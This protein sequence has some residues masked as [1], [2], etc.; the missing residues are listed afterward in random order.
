VQ[1]SLEKSVMPDYPM[2]LDHS[3]VG[4]CINVLILATSRLLRRGNG[5]V[6]LLQAILFLVVLRCAS[7]D[8]G[9]C[10]VFSFLFSC[11]TNKKMSC[12]R[13]FTF[14]VASRMTPVCGFADVDLAA[15]ICPDSKHELV[16][17]VAES[18]DT[19]YSSAI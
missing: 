6:R 16:E 9:F 13:V 4:F 17:Y 14:A 15:G 2:S 11:L 18:D 1:K 3:F 5:T 7:L 19:K 12:K 10:E 8:V